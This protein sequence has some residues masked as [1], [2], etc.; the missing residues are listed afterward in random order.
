MIK[1]DQW[2]SLSIPKNES[3]EFNAVKFA[4]GKHRGHFTDD[5]V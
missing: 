2:V 1:G 5:I 4:R 3:K